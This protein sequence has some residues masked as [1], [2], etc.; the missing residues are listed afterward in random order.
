MVGPA[1]LVSIP[2]A[3]AP[4]GQAET[5]L[6]HGDVP[7]RAALFPAPS[8][9]GSV[10]LSPGRTEPI[11]KYFEVVGELTGRGFCVLAHDWRGQGR[12]HRLLKD[13]LAGHAEGWRG[14]LG[15]YQRLLAAFEARLPRPWLALGHSMGGC[16]TLLALEE[17]VGEFS[18]AVLSAPM[19]KLRPGR[20]LWLSE[21]IARALVLA[22]RGARPLPGVAYDPIEGLF[23]AERLTHDPV[24]H[25]R[26]K[27][28]LR[29]GPDLALGHPTWGW[30]AFALQASRLARSSPRLR[31]VAVPVSIVGAELDRL[32]DTSASREVAA[33]LPQG[34][35]VEAP[36][37]F[38]EVLMETDERRAVFWRAFDD[39]ANEI[40]PRA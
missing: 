2:E 12:S 4:E 32:V 3:P 7:L 1:P 29:A 28:Q 27:A 21:L 25:H 19:L 38:H 31:R 35:Y 30:L 13:R 40:C 18:G 36:G 6:G 22:G 10:V 8:P 5:L 26:Y 14:F 20:P 34:R 15:D 16:L 9:R 37:A 11:E 33:A 23:E 24:R 17:G 39:L